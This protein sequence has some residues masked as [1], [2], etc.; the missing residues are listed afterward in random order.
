MLINICSVLSAR[1]IDWFEDFEEIFLVDDSTNGQ[2]INGEYYAILLSRN[3]RKT[4]CIEV[5]LFHE[6]YF[7]SNKSS[8]AMT[9]TWFTI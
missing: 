5:S 8:F 9:A 6:D 4:N 7:T 1:K 3:Q 2:T